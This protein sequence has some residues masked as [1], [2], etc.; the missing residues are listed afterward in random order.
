MPAILIAAF[1]TISI[2]AG[3]IRLSADILIAF[4]NTIRTY[5]IP[6]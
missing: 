5:I 3:A 6:K 1:T 4:P 2:S